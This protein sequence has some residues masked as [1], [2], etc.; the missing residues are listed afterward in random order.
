MH[1]QE[2]P[3]PPTSIFS[4]TLILQNQFILILIQQLDTDIIDTD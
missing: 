4:K 3:S 1:S 2:F